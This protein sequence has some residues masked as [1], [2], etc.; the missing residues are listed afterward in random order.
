[1]CIT[2]VYAPA[3]LTTR[4]TFFEKELTEKI[5]Q[6]DELDEPIIMMGDF[7]DFELLALDRWPAFE[8]QPNEKTITLHLNL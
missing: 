5:L 3:K 6:Y 4:R 7:N 2:S 1:L 8:K